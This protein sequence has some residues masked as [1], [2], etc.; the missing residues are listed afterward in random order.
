[1]TPDTC[2]CGQRVRLSAVKTRVN[3][4]AG[5]YHRIVHAD[6]GRAACGGDWSCYAEKPYPKDD[7]QREYRKLL[8]RW[9]AARTG[10]PS[11]Q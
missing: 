4:R 5:V 10:E 11:G 2:I 7:G 6:D 8:D 9:Q 3:G 1:M